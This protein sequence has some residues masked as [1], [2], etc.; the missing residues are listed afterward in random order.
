MRQLVGVEDGENIVRVD[1]EG[2]APQNV[3]ASSC[4]FDRLTALR[5]KK[6]HSSGEESAEKSEAN[7]YYRQFCGQFVEKEIDIGKFWLQREQ[8]I[9]PCQ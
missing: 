4:N 9:W 1:D 8:V 7:C 5:Q 3:S 2:P 6:R